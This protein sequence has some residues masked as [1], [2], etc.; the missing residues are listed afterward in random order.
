MQA[1]TSIS[2]GWKMA[3]ENADGSPASAGQ[4]AFN[5]M[6]NGGGTV[7]FRALVPI[8]L[9][10]IGGLVGLMWNDLKDGQHMT[11]EKL[12]QHTT[13]LTEQGESIVGYT[14]RIDAMQTGQQRI[15]IKIGGHDQAIGDMDHRVTRLEACQPNCHPR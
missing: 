5:F 12:D 7:T 8:L 13:I 4:R 9:T 6:A 2:Q 1:I 10:V 15:W 14:T 3:Q 11:L